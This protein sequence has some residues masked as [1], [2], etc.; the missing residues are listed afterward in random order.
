MKHL[1]EL[2]TLALSRPGQ[3]IAVAAAHDADVLEA[4]VKAAKAGIARPIFIGDGGKIA[5]LLNQMGERPG[6]YAIEDAPDD[7]ASAARA[8]ARVRAG[9]AGFLMKGLMPTAT[10]MRAVVDKATGLRTGRLL[11]HCMLYEVPGYPRLLN[12]TDGGMNPAPD[13]TKKAEIL[14]NAARVMQA[15]GYTE[16][17]AACLAGA[18]TVDPKIPATTDAA[19]LAEMNDRWSPYHMN[20]Y[21]PV[22]LDLAGS[23]A[24]CAHKRYTA[25]GAGR[26]DIL[27]VPTYEM[28]NG[29]GKALTYFASA[30]S[31]GII[32]G[33]TVPI[34]LVSRADTAETKLTSIAF[35]AAV[36]GH[37]G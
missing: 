9:E 32:V 27:L 25:P 26:A 16:I 7:A 4:A 18:E 19:A 35:G 3:A 23:E 31:A 11:S 17:N 10:L 28:G 33:A 37:R 5:E 22:G 13:L 36:S 14:E 24:A 8:V 12:N 30:K 2:H 34:V 1:S 20:V 15:L 21:G 29:I 6:D